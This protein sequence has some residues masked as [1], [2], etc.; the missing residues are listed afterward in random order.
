MFVTYNYQRNTATIAILIVGLNDRIDPISLVQTVQRYEQSVYY[1]TDGNTRI[2]GDRMVYSAVFST[3]TYGSYDYKV[4]YNV[5]A[6]FTYL[7]MVITS[8]PSFL[9]QDCLI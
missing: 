5:D 7:G 1:L 3:Q 2:E 6:L 8:L 4:I 9:P